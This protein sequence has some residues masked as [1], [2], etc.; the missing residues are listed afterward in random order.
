MRNLARKGK[1]PDKE[2]AGAIMTTPVTIDEIVAATE[3]NRDVI[4]EIEGDT[5][6]GAKS[7]LARVDLH[8]RMM[9]TSLRQTFAA[10]G[11][12]NP[13]QTWRVTKYIDDNQFKELVY[14]I[15]VDDMQKR[16]TVAFRGSETKKDWRDKTN[17]LHGVGD[18]HCRR[19]MVQPKKL[20]M[21]LGFRDY[22]FDPNT[23]EKEPPPEE[24]DKDE[25]GKDEEDDADKMRVV[26]T[27]FDAIMDSLYRTL[28]ENPG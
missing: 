6:F 4:D 8:K 2:T 26:N 3:A 9:K 15:C 22:V 5:D 16:I 25:E 11:D 14:A 21:H 28:E 7:E 13:T 12:L 18:S 17:L 1:M 10:L 24:V 19:G 27:K 20:V 23:S